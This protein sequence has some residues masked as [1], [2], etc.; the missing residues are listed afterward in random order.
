MEEKKKKKKKKKR[1]GGNLATGQRLTRDL[2]LAELCRPR[3]ILCVKCVDYYERR[4]GF[5]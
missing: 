3:S 4:I 5:Y 1:K 2:F